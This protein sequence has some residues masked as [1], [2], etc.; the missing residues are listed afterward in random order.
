MHLRLTPANGNDMDSYHAADRSTAVLAPASTPSLLRPFRQDV[1]RG[2][3]GFPKRIPSKYLYDARGSQLFDQICE[4]DEYYPTRIESQLMRQHGPS[5]ARCLGKE[6]V[7]VE[8]GSG[9]SEKSRIL[10]DHLDDAAAYLP[11]DI[12]ASHLHQA[13]R[14][15]KAAYPDVD[16]HPLVADFME[17]LALPSRYRGR[18][19]C[20]YFPGSTIGNLERDEA[21]RLLRN[22]RAMSGQR[23][24]LL[25]GFDLQKD[26]EVLHRAYNDSKGVTAAFNLNVLTRINRELNADFDV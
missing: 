14:S 22:I 8:L 18:S 10:L 9:S 12:S 23:G 3:K 15:I 5:M 20:T 21:A 11:V 13:S 6:I 26:A 16:V 25:V 24:G 4:L 19:V 1:L 7:L 17:P 2:L